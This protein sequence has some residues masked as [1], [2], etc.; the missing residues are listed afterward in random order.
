MI[1]Y[2]V[3][4][5]Q[6]S[7]GSE[8]YDR[9]SELGVRQSEILGDYFRTLGLRFDRAYSGSMQRQAATARTVLSRLDGGFAAAL[10]TSAAE[11]DEIDASAI[12][13]SQVAELI[14][15]DPS[16]SEAFTKIYQESWALRVVFERAMGRWASGEHQVPGCESWDNF[17]ARISRGLAKIAG[18][19]SPGENAVVFTSGGAISVVMQMALDLPDAE[20]L[21]MALEIRNS[22][23]STFRLR[24]NRAALVCFNSVAHLEALN[25][26]G[27]ITY[28]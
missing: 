1:F 8:N 13:R 22:S 2:L 16:I 5:A 9:L 4:H 23:V 24:E 28:R 20:T 11:F 19:T 21:R 7:F 25:D 12:I 27:L 18:E 10:V 6:A 26:P 14:R 3:R 17:R 15:E